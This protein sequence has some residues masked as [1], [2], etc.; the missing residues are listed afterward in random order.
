MGRHRHAVN[1]RTDGLAAVLGPLANDQRVRAAAL[2]DVDSGMVLDACG[3]D[4]AA[5]VPDPT[6]AGPDIEARGAAHAELVRTAT[7]LAAGR[8]G[9]EVVVHAADGSR[10]VLHQVADPHGDRLA[11]AVVLADGAP[12]VL[13]RLRRRLR[14][15]SAAAL[16]AGPSMA[17]RPT[18][19]GWEP[20][21]L[22]PHPPSV[23]APPPAEAPAPANHELLWRPS[24]PDAAPAAPAVPAIAGIPAQADDPLPRRRPGSAW[25]APPAPATPD[26][27]DRQAPDEAPPA[28][29]ELVPWQR[30]PAPPSALPPGASSP[31]VGGASA[32]ADAPQV[33]TQAPT[34]EAAGSPPSGSA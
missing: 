24:G 23:P 10:H 13:S 15:V 5:G 25:T 30:G 29:A 18:A 14:A 26:E 22:V 4:T 11:L 33:P 28:P 21:R 34:R 7:A 8:E 31:A 12:W 9:C 16:T 27:V 19:D 2:V 32:Q 3:P 17:L 6:G 1:V 20:N